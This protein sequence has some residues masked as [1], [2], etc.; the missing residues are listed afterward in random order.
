MVNKTTLRPFTKREVELVRL[1]RPHVERAHTNAHLIADLRRQA[2]A[3]PALTT[4]PAASKAWVQAGGLTARET[5]VLRWLAVGKRDNEI[6]RILGVS[7]YTVHSHVAKV[8]AKLK[9]ETRTAA[10]AIAHQLFAL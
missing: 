8:L 7:P 2:Q 1:L 3:Q 9:V 4:G 5:E 10:A 6:A